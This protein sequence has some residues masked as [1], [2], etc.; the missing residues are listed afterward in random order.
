MQSHMRRTSIINMDQD[1]GTSLLQLWLLIIVQPSHCLRFETQFGQQ[2]QR[3]GYPFV[4]DK[5]AGLVVN[6]GYLSNRDSFER[7]YTLFLI[8]T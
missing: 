1:I 2:L 4:P 8:G 6:P 3:Q 5:S 7:K